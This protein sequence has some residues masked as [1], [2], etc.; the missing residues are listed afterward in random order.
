MGLF[1][2]IGGALTG[3]ATGGPLGAAAGGIAGLASGGG[4]KS[5]QTQNS[6]STEQMKLA[7]WTPEQKATVDQAFKNLGL[8]GQAMTPEQ[9]DALRKSIYD[10][11]YGQASQEINQ[12]ADTQE[13]NRFSLAARRGAG[14]T[15][16]SRDQQLL[17][18]AGVQRN[19]GLASMQADLASRQQVIQEDANTRANMAA[20][21]ATLNEM[22]NQRKAGSKI[23]RTG[24]GT[25]TYTAADTFGQSIAAGLGSAITDKESWLNTKGNDFFGGV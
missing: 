18:Q 19:L 8:A 10:N 16:A 20:Q 25:Q 7:D 17:N 12:A 21:L 1:K 23:V 4:D 3:L 14:D 15:S 6:T 9:Q 11:M 13:A 22:W 5:T 24:G 2:A